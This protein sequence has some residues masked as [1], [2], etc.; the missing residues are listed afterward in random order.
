MD[1]RQDKI[2]VLAEKV[3]GWESS[4]YDQPK[5]MSEIWVLK[6]TDK[7]VADHRYNP[8]TSSADNDALIEAMATKHT[9]DKVI[10]EAQARRVEVCIIISNI[11]HCGTAYWTGTYTT[12]KK[13]EAVCEAIYEAITQE[14]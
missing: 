14:S 13:N 2:K 7:M 9:L 11:F 6:G 1:E 3:M 8:F 4:F 5:D 12:A 10:I